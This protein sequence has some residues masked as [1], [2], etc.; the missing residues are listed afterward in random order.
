MRK[1]GRLREEAG[2][3]MSLLPLLRHR[4]WGLAG[5]VALGVLTSLAEGFS[6][7]LFIPFLQ[8]MDA[9]ES[10]RTTGNWLVDSLAG[11][12]TAVPAERRLLVIALAIFA[13]LVLVSLLRY[14]YDMVFA[15]MD[16]RIGHRLRSGI[17]AQLLAVG[18]GFL[19]RSEFGRLLNTLSTE[20]WRTSSALATLVGLFIAVCTAA[21]YVALLL[22]LSWK[23]TLLVIVGLT[24]IS[25]IARAL[26]QRVKQLGAEAT[27]ANA[28]LSQRMMEGLGGM[29]VIRTFVREPYE[30]R[31]FDRASEEVTSVFW[32]LGLLSGIVTPVYEVL[33]AVLLVSVL[34]VSL[35]NTA[36]LPLLLVFIFVLYRLRPR[37]QSID[38]ARVRLTS[39]AASVRDV[40]GMLDRTDK[41]YITS[42]DTPFQALAQGI[43]FDDVTFRYAP[44]EDPALDRVSF[45]IPAGKTTAIVGPSGAGKST[46]IKLLFRFYD[47]DA[48][49]V[50]VDG[51][52]L[53]DFD[54]VAWRERIALVSQEV[55]LFNATIQENIA[56]G[57]LDAT[58]EEVIEAAKRA[59]AHTFIEGLPHGYATRTG[60]RGVRLSGGQQQRLTLARA[61]VRDPELFILD[62][63]TNALD[64]ISENAIQEALRTFGEDRTVVVIA[65]RLSTI[66][67]ADHL[68]VLD[69]GRVAEQGTLQELL[70]QDGLFARL[71]RLQH[72]SALN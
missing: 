72:R 2:V 18:Y 43:R 16:V 30:Q 39:L 8:S 38:A 40:M 64:T 5:L 31:R 60:D 28:A 52:P 35:Q 26:T 54:L 27:E 34:Y 59:D 56:Y 68:I 51:Q 25:M 24:L 65:H 46:L 55:Y 71:Y 41:P 58:E 12:F 47:P 3:A 36:N 11:L 67:H 70:D 44:D 50:V 13:L 57:R 9:G 14:A 6:V 4:T 48:G 33:A 20:T 10:V 29:K 21:V 62:E 15:W 19:E 37:I 61:I 49:T 23:L 69:E 63:A 66:E 53:P 32:R 1:L 45:T 42:G 17:Y 22:L 7:S